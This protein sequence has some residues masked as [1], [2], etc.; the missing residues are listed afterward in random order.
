ME[1][2]EKDL[3]MIIEEIRKE[4]SE[5]AGRETEAD[6][7]SFLSGPETEFTHMIYRCGTPM[8]LQAIL[9]AVWKDDTKKQKLIRMISVSVFKRKHTFDNKYHELELTNYTMV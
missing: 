5:D 1:Q 6:R 9:G 7:D 4:D 3:Q 8:D 2:I